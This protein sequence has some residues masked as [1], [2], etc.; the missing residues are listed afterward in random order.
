MQA[1]QQRS[2]DLC[3]TTNHTPSCQEQDQEASRIPKIANFQI[4]VKQTNIANFNMAYHTKIKVCS[5]ECFKPSTP[6]RCR[7][8]CKELLFGTPSEGLR[9][10]HNHHNRHNRH[11]PHIPRLQ[12]FRSLHSQKTEKTCI[13]QA[14]GQNPRKESLES[15]DLRS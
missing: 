11:N 13:P 15:L 5:F 7:S 1:G 8:S 6:K 2:I 9:T 14:P 4:W 10:R 12:E 3:S